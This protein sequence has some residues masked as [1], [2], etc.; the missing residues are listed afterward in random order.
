M[1]TPKMHRKPSVKS[2]IDSEL[3]EKAKN[4]IAD[5][6]G[7]DRACEADDYCGCHDDAEKIIALV[8]QNDNPLTSG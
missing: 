8:R 4:I 5:G 2:M 6:C 7:C 3:I 1:L